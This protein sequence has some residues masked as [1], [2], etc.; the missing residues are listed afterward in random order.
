M[1]LALRDT[2]AH[3]W[4]V[5]G[6]GECQEGQVWE[7]AM[8][9]A[10]LEGRGLHAVVDCNRYQEWGWTR[11]GLPDEPVPAMLAKWEAFGWRVFRADGHHHDSLAEKFRS[12]AECD[13]P[14]VVLAD[15]VKGRGFPIIEADP[16]RFH[17]T[18]VTPDEQAQLLEALQ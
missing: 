9:A 4:V 17:C 11:N 8:L 6:D 5:L 13:A 2:G 1:A 12:A 7:A 16:R 15:T 18:S 10:R 14:S 3:V